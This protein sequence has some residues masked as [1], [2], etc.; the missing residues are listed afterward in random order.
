MG[1]ISYL[2]RRWGVGP[3]R[4]LAILLAF[5]LAGMTVVRLKKPVIALLLSEDATGWVVWLV[6]LAVGVPLYYVLLMG[7]G[8]L[9][10]Q[11]GFFRERF[12]KLGRRFG[13]R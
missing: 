10:G 11:Y 8:T 6:H 5:S 1:L 7:Y 13:S 2:E 12:A 9:L 4:V 3:W